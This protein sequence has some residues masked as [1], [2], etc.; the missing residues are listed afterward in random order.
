MRRLQIF[1]AL[2][3]PAI[4]FFVSGV[5]SAQV[6]Q[7]RGHVLLRQADGTTVPAAGA[8]IDVY[9]TDVAG[10]YDTKA[11]KKGQFVFA[12]LPFVGTYVISASAPNAQPTAI[13]GA[14]AGR[15]I[16]F[17]VVLNPGDGKRFT[18]AEAKAS[19]GGAR[20]NS[21]T[22][23]PPTES[24]ADKAK[25]EEE[26]K[27]YEAEKN[28]VTNV[29]EVLNRTFKAGNE[30]LT[31]KNYDEAL[32][33]YDE[34]LAADPEQV[35]FYSRKSAALRYRGVD[36]YNASIKATDATVKTNEL[37]SAKKDFQASVEAVQRGVELSKK[38]AAAT[39][40]VGQSN[41]ALRKLDVLS[42]RAESMRLL[43][44]VDPTQS[45]A[46]LIAYNE[47]MAVEQDAAKKAKAEKDLA[48]IMFDSSSDVAGFERAL[49]AYK[50]ILEANPEDV[51]AV[52][53]IG[54]A[55]FNI[56]A[57]NNNDKA[58][59]QEAANYLQLYVNKAPEGQLKS[60][61]KDL[62]EA[63]KAQANVTPEKINTP[64]RRRRP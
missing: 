31:A 2:V 10:K 18:E 21:D 15:E 26:L 49:A 53:R 34:G 64:P 60:E 17:E 51:D 58:K 22:T 29:N 43:M 45:D 62:I 40:A 6:G 46:T 42:N 5:A 36:H 20:G 14:K 33:Q 50:K 56:G 61:A 4:L 48:Q 19:A 55:L 16:D 8:Q 1:T 44:K 39:D 12:G 54:Q 32:K 7:M 41:Q 24:A 30:A 52:L 38:E 23:K 57:L 11:D 35:I 28:R 25:R 3:A 37:E 13:G 47:Y 59:Y 9:R 63:L 27:K